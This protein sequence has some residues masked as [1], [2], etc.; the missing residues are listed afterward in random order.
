MIFSIPFVFAVLDIESLITFYIIF[1]TPYVMSW[2]SNASIVV[3][4]CLFCL[5]LL[6][7]YILLFICSSAI[8]TEVS[9]KPVSNLDISFAFLAFCY[10][11]FMDFLTF[12]T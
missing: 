2:T 6:S 5:Y 9:D 3:F 12:R 1:I 7:Q 11:V 8:A 10:G 4:F